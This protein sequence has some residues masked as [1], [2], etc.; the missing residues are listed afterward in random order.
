MA[1]KR[2][3]R[4]LVVFIPFLLN[5]CGASGSDTS[6]SATPLL[7]D[8]SVNGSESESGTS[9]PSFGAEGVLD[10]TRDTENT[11]PDKLRLTW[12]APATRSD[13]TPLSLSEIAG[14]RIHWGTSPSDLKPIAEVQD[15]QY[16]IDNL[17]SG[18]HYFSLTVY[19][20]DES[21]ST[22]TEVLPLTVP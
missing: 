19:D 6:E 14:Y 22:M 8:S 2:F 3:P 18:V 5:G 7:E 20:S 15:T 10:G 11:A 21:E 16:T 9:D 17:F 12:V 13:G 4:A 1:V